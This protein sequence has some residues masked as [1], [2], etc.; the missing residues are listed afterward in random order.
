MR[1]PYS[2][3][4]IGR[5]WLCSGSKKAEEG[6]PEVV[7]P[8]SESG[9]LIH[10]VCSG[11][12]LID[13]LTEDEKD[14][15][16]E[17]LRFRDDALPCK[18]F[19]TEIHM[20]LVDENGVEVT[21]GTADVVAWTGGPDEYASVIEPGPAEPK[22]VYVLDLKTGYQPQERTSL[23]F[24]MST[25]M[26]MAIQRYDA[27]D[28]IAIVYQPRIHKRYDYHLSADEVP[29]TVRLVQR[30]IANCERKQLALNPSSEACRFCKARHSC[31]GPRSLAHPLVETGKLSE[32]P[33]ERLAELWEFWRVVKKQGEALEKVFRS[34]VREHRMP[35]YEMKEIRG[36]RYFPSTR[37]A[38]ASVKDE[39]P[40]QEFIEICSVSPSKLEKAYVEKVA[41]SGVTKAETV[42]EFVEKTK[43][44]VQRGKPKEMVTK[45]EDE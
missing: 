6:L 38:F 4:Q 29:D 44:V 33:A 34:A 12:R 17:W 25:Y 39:I 15:V 23:A 16:R 30:T 28:A 10:A 40:S 26:A 9:S 45:T 22:T 2:A 8:E 20:A 13:E 24:Q 41:G 18:N 36:N 14:V 3:S 5:R 42:R 21:D 31:P 1:N 19:S 7:S 35:G 32:V 27:D 37:E 11:E 43:A